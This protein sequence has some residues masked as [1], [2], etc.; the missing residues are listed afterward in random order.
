[1][2]SRYIAIDI[3]HFL[4]DPRIDAGQPLGLPGLLK[5]GEQVVAPLGPGHFR[6]QLW[7]PQLLQHSERVDGTIAHG[8]LRGIGHDKEVK[9]AVRLEVAATVEE[10]LH[11]AFDLFRQRWPAEILI[12]DVDELGHVVDG[13]QVELLDVSLAF[14]A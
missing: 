10:V 7:A 6:H 9:R 13:L 14:L 5:F 1:M 2:S 11:H 3:P 8:F 4:E 12:L